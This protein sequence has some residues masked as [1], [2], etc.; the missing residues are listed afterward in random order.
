MNQ[1]NLPI[2]SITTFLPLVGALILLA[3]PRANEQAIKRLALVASLVT[4][5][6]SLVL[7]AYFEIGTSAMQ[8]T[9]SLPW[10]SDLGISYQLG[11]DGISLWLVLLTTFL[12]PLAILSSWTS[13]KDRL[14]EYMI[15]MLLLETGMIG[16]FVATDLFLFYVFWEAMLIPMY[17]LIGVWGGPRRVYAAVKFVLFTMAGSVLMLIAILAVAF[18]HQDASGRLT[19]DLIELMK[20]PVDAGMQTWLFA[21]FAL[22]FAIKVPLFPLHTWLPDAHVEAPTAGSVLL[23]GVLLKMG[24]YGYLRF[25]IPLFPQAALDFAPL[26]AA[27]AIIGIIYGALVALMQ[28]DVKKLVAYSSVSHLG[29]VVLGMV[30]FTAQGLSGGILQMVNHG[31]STG[32]L[33][34]LVG[35]LYER[36]HT[37]VIAD[38]GGLAKRMPVFTAF[39]LIVTLASI[40]LP[41]LNGFV[42][43]FTILLGVFRAN[44]LWAVLA[45]SGVVLSAWYML[46]M[47]QRMFHGEA[48]PN[49]HTA[50]LADVDKREIAIL[51]PILIL[52]FL[53][54]VYPTP[55]FDVMQPSVDKLLAIIGR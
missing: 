19:F 34:L 23:A 43:E 21:A 42:G 28:P 16:V 3:V 11:V 25:A 54:G 17:F 33:F 12:T 45:A 9:E 6:V 35:M 51:V 40:G 4:F 39:F 55:F 10:I 18:L 22:A 20:T 1:L 37:R 46:G 47:Y 50:H 7:Y 53:I 2:L 26:L 30:A 15:V 36:T 32:A 44:V 24:V 29:F 31:L 41:G 48:T 14:K 27:L 38:Y 5:A 8:F 49:E 52:I 13:V